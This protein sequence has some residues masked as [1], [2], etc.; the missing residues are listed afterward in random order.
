MPAHVRRAATQPAILPNLVVSGR[1]CRWDGYAQCSTDAL[2]ILARSTPGN[3][4]AAGAE[5]LNLA[6]QSKPTDWITISSKW[7]ANPSA[8]EARMRQSMELNATTML[9][10]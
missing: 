7:D 6:M 4:L 10:F 3:M 5:A 9:H 1:S 2:L 8:R